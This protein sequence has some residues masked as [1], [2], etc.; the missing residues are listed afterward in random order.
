MTAWNRNKYSISY[1]KS[2]KKNEAPIQQ[3]TIGHKKIYNHQQK[4]VLM[5]INYIKQT[6][7]IKL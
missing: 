2:P 3:G 5:Y 6:H 1:P 7:A 4:L